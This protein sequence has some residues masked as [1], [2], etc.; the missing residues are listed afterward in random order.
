MTEKNNFFVQIFAGEMMEW[1]TVFSYVTQLN[2]F[3]G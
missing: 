2:F 3:D 1:K